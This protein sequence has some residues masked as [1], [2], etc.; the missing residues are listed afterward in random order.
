M[1]IQ[2]FLNITLLATFLIAF[3]AFITKQHKRQATEIKQED[4]ADLPFPTSVMNGDFS[5]EVSEEL[6]DFFQDEEVD[7]DSDA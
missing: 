1:T 5:F 2:I 3:K 7:L 6:V 4:Q